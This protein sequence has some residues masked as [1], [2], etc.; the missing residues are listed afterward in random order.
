MA[1]WPTC[2]PPPM[3]MIALAVDALEGLDHLD[4]AHDGERAQLGDGRVRPCPGSS[5][6]K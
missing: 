5:T 6:S 1:T 3:M 4:R 2:A